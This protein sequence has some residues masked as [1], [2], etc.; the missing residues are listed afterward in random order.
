MTF[1]DYLA[2]LEAANPHLFGA[3]QIILTPD[4]LRKQLRRAYEAGASEARGSQLFSELFPPLPKHNGK[5]R[6]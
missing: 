4:S 5:R 6:Q 1:P 3:R 2:E